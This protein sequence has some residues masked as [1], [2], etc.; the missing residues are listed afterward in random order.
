MVWFVLRRDAHL[1]DGTR[2]EFSVPPEASL[3]GRGALKNA[4]WFVVSA[5]GPRVDDVRSLEF[6]RSGQQ[7]LRIGAKAPE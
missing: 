2:A 3:K 1:E 7:H 4:A 6:N 5:P